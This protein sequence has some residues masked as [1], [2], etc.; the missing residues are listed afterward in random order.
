M[1]VDRPGARPGDADAGDAID[2][3]ALAECGGSRAVAVRKRGNEGTSSRV[4]QHRFLVSSQPTTKP[5]LK[6]GRRL[7]LNYHGRNDFSRS[8]RPH[9]QLEDQDRRQRPAWI[10]F[11]RSV[12]GAIETMRRTRRRW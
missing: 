12:D 2:V 4:D 5:F 9:V 7:T 6:K 1:E 10:A 3:C 11:L 8:R